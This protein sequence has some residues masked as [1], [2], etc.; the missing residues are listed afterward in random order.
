MNILKTKIMSTKITSIKKTRIFK[1]LFVVI[2]LLVLVQTNAYSQIKFQN[3]KVALISESVSIPF[4]QI[5]INP[6]HPGISIGSDLVV[7]DQTSWYKSLGVEAG[8]YY[9]EHYEHAIM[10]DATG[11]FGYTFG[12]GLQLH[13]NGAL[14]YKHSILTGETYKFEGG[15]Y[16]AKGYAAQS[17]FNIKLGYGLE[18]PISERISLGADYMGMIALPYAPDKG[19]P[20]ST[21]GILKLGTKIKL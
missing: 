8:Y 21:H 14:G 6:I 3:I 13:L 11:Q 17:Q 9:H 12:I 15:E 7:K 10:L 19:K 20:F 2:M 4:G 5:P 18:F 16:K 1:L